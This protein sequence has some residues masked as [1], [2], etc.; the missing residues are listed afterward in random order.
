MRI[1]ARAKM[2]PQEILITNEFTINAKVI[3]FIAVL[4]HERRVCNFSGPGK[5]HRIC[6]TM[7]NIVFLLMFLE[8]VLCGASHNHGHG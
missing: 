6:Q 7:E 5:F 4:K 1:R 8:S 2:V 3:V